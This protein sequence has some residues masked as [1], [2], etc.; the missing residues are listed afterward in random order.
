MHS[1]I[2]RTFAGFAATLASTALTTLAHADEQF[3]F[4]MVRSP[5]LSAAPACVP[6]AHA[7]VRI[8]PRGAVEEM[9]VKMEGLPPNEQRLSDA[10][11][12]LIEGTAVHGV[13]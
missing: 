12:T 5:A 4:D 7:T 2:H 11:A 3:K 6:N 8:E 9:F 10:E 1:M 13:R